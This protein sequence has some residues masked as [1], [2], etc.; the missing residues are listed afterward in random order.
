M[1]FESSSG[2]MIQMDPDASSSAEAL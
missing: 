1:V 2:L